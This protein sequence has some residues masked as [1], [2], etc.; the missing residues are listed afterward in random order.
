MSAVLL[1]DVEAVFFR[2]YS[3][4]TYAVLHTK[5]SANTPAKVIKRTGM[6]ECQTQSVHNLKEFRVQKVRD[7]CR[8]KYLHKARTVS[9]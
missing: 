5:I 1:H 8:D 2:L 9:V 3:H 6:L 7:R 4:Y